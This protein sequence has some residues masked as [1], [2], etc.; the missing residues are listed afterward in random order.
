ME[1]IFVHIVQNERVARRQ[2]P[3][4]PLDYNKCKVQMSLYAHFQKRSMKNN[5]VVPD[6]FIIIPN[7]FE[8]YKV[9]STAEQNLLPKD[10]SKIEYW[11]VRLT[12]AAKKRISKIK[13]R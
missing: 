11:A 6:K 10:R 7:S 2:T 3:S 1:R 12:N 8:P 13:L 4:A 9:L 5:V